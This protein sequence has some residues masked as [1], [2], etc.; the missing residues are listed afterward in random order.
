MTGCD[1]FFS[2]CILFLLC[3]GQGL[4]RWACNHV[5]DFSLRQF[6]I[7]RKT[8]R[9]EMSALKIH[10]DGVYEGLHLGIVIFCQSINHVHSI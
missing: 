1:S 8:G 4:G 9:N 6:G 7:P 10:D 3:E 5:W 2:T